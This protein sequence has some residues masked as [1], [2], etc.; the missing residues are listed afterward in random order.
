MAGKLITERVGVNGDVSF[1]VRVREAGV[2]V[3]QL[4]FEMLD[5][6]NRHSANLDAEQ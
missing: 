3:I 4:K 1:L 2:A 6:Q 5:T